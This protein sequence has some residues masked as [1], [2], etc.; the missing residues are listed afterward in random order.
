[1]PSR[2]L[3]SKLLI[4]ATEA[5]KLELPFQN[6]VVTGRFKWH[7]IKPC[8]NNDVRVRPCI[9][10]SFKDRSWWPDLLPGPG[11]KPWVTSAS[12]PWSEAAPPPSLMVCLPSL[13]WPCQGYR[14]NPG[15]LHRGL[16]NPC[17]AACSASGAC[18]PSVI[19][20]HRTDYPGSTAF[21][22]GLLFLGIPCVGARMVPLLGWPGLLLQ[23][24]SARG[25][26]GRPGSWVWLS[27]WSSS[28]TSSQLSYLTQHSVLKVYLRCSMCQHFPLF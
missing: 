26:A 19:C 22:D 15:V 11:Q 25:T 7:F 27:M 5:S 28:C 1:M 24:R 4:C 8:F 2:Q 21:D 23:L 13:P 6:F 17:L 10:N 20:C 14:K 9:P 16:D 12:S 18:R 3:H